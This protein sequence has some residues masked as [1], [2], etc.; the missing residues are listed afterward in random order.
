MH[1][2]TIEHQTLSDRSKVYNV[3]LVTGLRDA[4]GNTLILTIGCRDEGSAYDLR[5]ALNIASFI[6]QRA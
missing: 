4:A 3:T 6:E 2:A 1:S 5:Q